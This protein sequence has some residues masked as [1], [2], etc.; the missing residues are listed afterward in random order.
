MF[1][2]SWDIYILKHRPTFSRSPS[3]FE[4]IPDWLISGLIENK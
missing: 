4:V 2:D 3:P 1:S